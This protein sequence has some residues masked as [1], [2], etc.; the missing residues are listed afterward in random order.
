MNLL[1]WGFLWLTLSASVSSFAFL[2]FALEWR[3]MRGA[4]PE[5]KAITLI[6]LF[7][8]YTEWL[9]VLARYYTVTGLEERFDH[10][11]DCLPWQFRAVPITII[12]TIICYQQIQKIKERKQN[13]KVRL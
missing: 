4:S 2:L 9:H 10:L 5:F 13:E 3:R 7:H 6:F 12:T 11:L 1:D 8:A